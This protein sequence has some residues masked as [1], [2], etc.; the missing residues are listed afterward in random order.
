M[1]DDE[2]NELEK[3]ID[4][5]SHRDMAVFWRFGKSEDP[6]IQDKELFKQFRAR[7]EELG[8]MTAE[9]SKDIGWGE[10]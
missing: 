2:R 5:M 9:L 1:T 3:R 6:I 4:A 8:G 7:F 10:E